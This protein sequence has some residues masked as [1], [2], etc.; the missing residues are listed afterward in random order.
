MPLLGVVLCL[1]GVVL[2]QA[3]TSTG[4]IVG[5]IRDPSGALVPNAQV[6]VTNQG[7][8]TSFRYTTSGTGDYYVPSLIPG[9]YRVEVEKPGF[10]KV[11]VAD[12]LVEVDRTSR[13]DISL[14]VGQVTEA[15]QV[16]APPTQVQTDTTTLGQV[17][18]S[19]QVSELPLNGRDFTN[20]LFLNTGVGQMQG[21]IITGIRKHGL[22]DNFRT[23]SVNGA[24][25][26]SI[27][28]VVDGVS[29]NDSL[30][31]GI[32]VVP[33]IDAL[34]EFKLQNGLYSADFGMGAAQV[35]IALKSG[36]NS[37]HGSL[38][39]FLRNNALQPAQ[40]FFHTKTPLKQNQFGGT[41]GGPAWIPGIYKGKDRTF[42][43]FSYEAGRRR[44]G[45]IS[46]AQVPT[47]QEKQGNFSD[48]PVQLFNPLTS[49]P[50]PAFDPNNPRPD[51][52]PILRDPFPNNQIPSGMIAQT[53]KNLLQY[54]PSPNINCKLPCF[55][56]TRGFASGAI[57]TDTFTVRGDHNFT[58][59]DRVFGQFLYEDQLAPSPSIIPLS[60]TSV[61][62]QGRLA[63]LQWTHVFG[64]RTMNE[65]RMGYNR[66]FYLSGFETAFGSTNYW[67]Q[68]GL[69][70]LRD[71]PAYFALPAVIPGTSYNSIGNGGSV[72]FFNIT[73]I[74]QW[75][76]SLTM[77]RGRHSIKV[78]ADIR[79]NQ[80]MNLNGFG[81]NG[82]LSFSG[83]YTAQNPTVA[84]VGGAPFAGNGF[85]DF[86]LGYMSPVGSNPAVRFTAFDQSFSRLRNTD[87][88]LF[89]QDD[90]RVTSGLTLN[91]GLR[92]EL[93]TPFHDKSKGGA[94]FDF[95]F[96]GGRAMYIDQSYTQ[97]LVSP[98]YYACCAQDSLINTDW[99]DFA[100]RIGLA[101]RPLAGNNKF[102]VRAGYGIFYDVIHNFYNTQS[103]SQNV[104]FANP[105]LPNA[106]GLE[107]QPPLDIRN[108]FPGPVPI[109][110]RQF[111]QPYCQAP[112][113]IGAVDPK[114]GLPT[115]VQNAC[116]GFQTQLPDNK[117][118]YLQQW[119]LNLEYEVV[120]NLM[121]EIGYQGSHGLREPI[122][123][124]FN[125]AFLPPQAGNPNNSVQFRS[126]C[127]P[128]TY[129][130]NCSPFQD[131]VPYANFSWSAF[132]NANILQSV[133][134]AM[135]VKLDKRFSGGLSALVSFTWGRAIDQFSEIQAY[136]GSVSSLAQYA[137]RMDL[138]RGPAGFDQT[139]RFVTSWTYEL[140]FGQGKALLNRGGLAN[141]LAGGWQAN[142]IV[143]LSDGTP[144]TVGCF[145][146]DRGQTGNSATMRPNLNANPLPSGF[147]QTL[148]QWFDT[149]AFSLPPLGTLGT[150]GRNILRSTG[151]R[152]TDFSAFKNN[153][154]GERINLQFRA[155]FFNLFSSKFYFP[156]FPNSN[157]S[158]I[159]FSRFFARTQ[160]GGVLF[161]P[162]VIQFG[163]RL[164]I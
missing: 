139:R 51:V 101:W 63:S 163:L 55:N 159:N 162:R 144:F 92:W 131:R 77:T 60:G 125:Q 114:T 74:F 107:S 121:V 23:G 90:F 25:P 35:N 120:R 32:S 46:Q 64:S 155:E 4:I 84:Q 132:A 137:Q 86:L 31:Q 102:V 14:E 44:S 157:F 134:H 71:D 145:C 12:V 133:Y 111:P 62:Q 91:L 147:N 21:G 106:T 69:V 119:G 26:A 100:P 160:D 122:Q 30:F 82:L 123:W 109:G 85:A 124:R 41:L 87:F 70:N 24:R 18:G 1:I 8:N 57:D 81:G 99:H 54:F 115:V 38:W 98:I 56:F 103:V 148:T 10:K 89:Y 39:E 138:E 65:V 17:I 6:A 48:W 5:V 140:P 20:L 117:T 118:P 146:G 9:R 58:A 76:D 152:A 127:P 2:L 156:L 108:M 29:M 94:V 149:S 15:V 112:Q 96:P 135:T 13:V 80:N 164:I 52:P 130:A 128:G 151:Q 40:P 22:N 116:M 16:S 93:H 136:A 83:E 97:Q 3:Q 79:R 42:F 37:F 36:T 154:I 72:P 88:M 143:T 59:R 7:T 75:S 73:N 27:S 105:S 153:K 34:E 43:F 110:G 47:D 104:P 67:K 33:P 150:A 158:D 66:I 129:P 19:R 28:F 45:A 161:N 50:N 61:R 126:Q 142:G 68:V 113:S 95:G 53:S 11:T 49:K 141:H 78:G